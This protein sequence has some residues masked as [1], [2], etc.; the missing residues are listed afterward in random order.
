MLP[1]MAQR[2]LMLAA[3]VALCT[4]PAAA[5]AADLEGI[6]DDVEDGRPLTKAA[7]EQMKVTPQAW[8]CA[9][10]GIAAA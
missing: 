10:S 2:A 1:T 3:L 7:A 6:E 9:M 8:L 5:R 4:L